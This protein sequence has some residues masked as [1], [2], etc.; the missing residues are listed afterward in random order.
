[1]R[2]ALIE[3]LC[4]GSALSF[5]KTREDKDN[6]PKKIK[7]KIKKIVDTKISNINSV[8]HGMIKPEDIDMI[9]LP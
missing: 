7:I 6:K 5:K 8:P 1:M 9:P 2:K 4:K 3:I